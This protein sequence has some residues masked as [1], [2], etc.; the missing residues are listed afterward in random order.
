VRIPTNCGKMFRFVPEVSLPPSRY[1]PAMRLKTVFPTVQAALAILA[2]TLFATPAAFAQE[3]V[4]YSFRG[5]DGYQ[6]NSTLVF[7]SAGNLYGT[8]ETGGP[9]GCHSLGCGTVF[10]LM[11]A[12][13]VGW[14]EK[15]IHAFSN[16]GSDG[17]GPIAGVIFDAA[18]NLYGTTEFGGNGTCGQP[19]VGC[20]TVFELT[21]AP[22]GN[23]KETV[24]YTFQNNGQ[25]GN[26]PYAAVVLDGSGN[27]YGSTGGGGANNN[28]TVFQLSLKADGVWHETVLHSFGHNLGDGT[29]PEAALV[30]DASG[31]LYGTTSKG[32]QG[33]LAVGTVFELSPV[34]GGS[35]IEKILHSFKA[36]GDGNRPEGNLTMDSS[37]NLYGTTIFGG[38]GGNL[39]TVFELSPTTGGV[40]TENLLF[41]FSVSAG[42]A[43]QG[44]VLL[45]PSGNLYGTTDL[46]VDEVTPGIV[47]ELTPDSRGGWTERTVYDFQI[48]GRNGNRP[49]SGLTL[50]TS[51]NLYGTTFTG[52]APCRTNQFGCGTVYEVT[53]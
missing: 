43:P 11:P 2:L 52:G 24:L 4:L 37:G 31:N 36:N 39:G 48:D 29:A 22:T 28:G 41:S 14:T 20:G 32:G 18:G 23:W 35:W 8:T 30:I 44:G 25:D 7:D 27:L 38:T 49:Q 50:D 46:G 12:A 16:T 21:P 3:K 42:A 51:G 10:E 17:Y 13:G 45:G 5:T 26:F 40:W 47:F 6:P 15:V 34:S 19:V 33:R 9:P 53:P 1:S